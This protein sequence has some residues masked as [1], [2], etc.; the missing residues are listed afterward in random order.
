MVTCQRSHSSSKVWS[1]DP[2][3]ADRPWSLQNEWLYGKGPLLPHCHHATKAPASLPWTTAVT[4]I[5]LCL[6][7]SSLLGSPSR[8]MSFFFFFF[9]LP[10]HAACR[11]LGTEIQDVAVKAE[12]VNH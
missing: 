12:N 5:V 1:Q 3:Q 10:C 2:A 11:I 8:R 7:P 4:S 9:F 6:V